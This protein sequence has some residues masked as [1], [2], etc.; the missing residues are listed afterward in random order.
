MRR[1]RRIPEQMVRK[2]REA[3]RMPG[4][5]APLFLVCRHLEQ[6]R[7]ERIAAGEISMAK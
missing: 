1:R 4:E 5:G 7:K 6:W 3:D 2:L